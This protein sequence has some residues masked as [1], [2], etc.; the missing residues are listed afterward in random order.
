MVG[1]KVVRPNSWPWLVELLINGTDHYCGGSLLGPSWVLTTAHCFWKYKSPADW[2]VAVGEHNTTEYEGYEERIG[3]EA[4]YVHPGFILGADDNPGDYDIALVR[5]KRPAVFHKRVHSVCLPGE[6]SRPEIGKG[7][8]VVGWGKQSEN[9][10]TYS[11]V[12]REV[13]VPLVSHEVCNSNASYGGKINRHFLC[14]G[15]PQGLR[16]GCYGDS[17]GPLVCENKDNVMT[18]T[19][20]VSWGE[21]CARPRKYGVYSDVQRLLPFI[22]STMQGAPRGLSSFACL[23]SSFLRLF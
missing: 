5:L 6:D 7:C 2:D 21:G 18:L 16:D 20:L 9:S 22:Q 13:E 8:F 10:S 17:G 1:G 11:E 12:P 3:V 14:A 15:Y 4:I 19:G 23:F